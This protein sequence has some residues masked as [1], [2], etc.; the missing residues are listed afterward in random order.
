MPHCHTLLWVTAPSQISSGS[1]VDKYISAE[2]PDPVVNPGLHA[3]VTN[4]MF[5]GPCGLLNPAA[6]CMQ[7][8]KCTR[9]FP[10]PFAAATI[11]DKDGYV[12][13][14]RDPSMS[15][16]LDSGIEIHNGYIVPYNPRLS[17]RFNAH[18][19]VE[20]CGWNMLIKYLFK[21]ISKGVDRIS[22]AIR[23]AEL[24]FSETS[25]STPIEV[26]EVQNFIDGRYICAH[27]AA[28]RIFNYSIHERW[29]AVQILAVHLRDMQAT[30]FEDSSRLA[31]VVRHPNFGRTTLTAWF[32]Y[33]RKY[34]DGRHLIYSE[35]PSFYR[36]EARTREWVRRCRDFSPAVGRMIYVHPTSGELFFCE[37]FYVIKKDVVVLKMF[38]QFVVAFYLRFDLHAMFWVSLVKIK[39]GY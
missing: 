26:D 22:F 23:K 27:E 13:Y 15:F 29:P 25:T 8:G 4:C 12:H 33:N 31:N 39:N 35:F 7:N 11:I 10:K 19:N 14:K 30:R 24:R 6:P 1:D 28:W 17:S 38:V 16:T 20:Y 9:N 3:I 2:L 5:H 34:S 21:Y 37:C 36:W 18:I 32:E